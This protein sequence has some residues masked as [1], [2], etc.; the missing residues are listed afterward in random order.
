MQFEKAYSFLMD[1]LEKELPPFLH[2][3]NAQHTKDVLSGAEMLA[4]SENISGDDLVILKTAALFHDSGFLETYSDHEEISCNMARKW[5]PPFGYNTDEIEQICQLI[6]ATKIPQ[7]PQNKLAQILCDADLYYM[8]TDRYFTGADQLYKELHEAGMVKSREEWSKEEIKFVAAHHYFTPTAKKNLDSKIKKTLTLLRVR[9]AGK[10]TPRKRIEIHGWIS[11]GIFIIVGVLLAAF[12]LKGFLI[13]NGFFDGGITG[14]SL[15]ISEITKKDISWI[16]MVANLPFIIICIYAINFNYALKTFFCILLL[17]LCLYFFPHYSIT[18]D[19]LLVSI[20]GGFFLG[21]GIG[22]TMRAGC[23]IDGIE[24]LALYTWKKTSFTITEIILA[25]NILIFSIAAFR[26]G[27]QIALY[28]ML[29]YFTASRTVDY[30]VEGLEA[31]IGVTIISSKSEIIKDRLVNE[32]GRGITIYKGERGF[33]PGKF[34][35]HDDCDII[36]TVITRL[37]IRKLKNL[38]SE[39]DPRSFV[40]ASTIKEAS[41]GIIKRRHVH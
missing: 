15:L 2:Y 21:A 7:E 6:L 38:V 20:F 40:F 4:N 11:D 31:Y 33:L 36:F 37:E 9:A 24:I 13:P 32:M 3:H 8:G 1:R 10:N 17:G 16:I 28:S 35:L 19:K 18:S 30:V 22:L 34:D 26:F 25:I 41:G 23:A 14:I 12:S 5:L 39:I 27:I 29:T